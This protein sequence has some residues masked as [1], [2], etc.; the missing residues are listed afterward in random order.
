MTH[1]LVA[2]GQASKV[3]R[4][5]MESGSAADVVRWGRRAGFSAYEYGEHWLVVEA[6]NNRE[7]LRRA[8]ELMRGRGWAGSRRARA[9]GTGRSWLTPTRESMPA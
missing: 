9:G 6:R 1:Y 4:R 8:A 3:Q 2:E 7:A 5:T